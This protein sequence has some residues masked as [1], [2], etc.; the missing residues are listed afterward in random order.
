MRLFI[1]TNRDLAS[2]YNL[3]LLLP[4]ICPLFDIRVFVSDKVG[5][6]SAEAPPEA[7]Q[8]LKFFEQ[9]MPNQLLFPALE[10]QQREARGQLLTFEELSRHYNIP[11]VSWNDVRS[12][13]SLAQLREWAPDLVL[14]VRYGKIFPNRFLAIPKHGVINL[15]SGL[16][17]NYRGVLAI[18]RALSNGDTHIY[19]TLHYIDDNSIDTGRVIGYG[20][21]AVNPQ[22]SL[23]WHILHLYPACTETIVEA[24][25]QIREGRTPAALSQQQE[26]AAYYT[27]P[28]AAEIE[29]FKQKGWTWLDTAAYQDF[30]AQYL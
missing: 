13:E 27:F 2:N 26:N 25:S 1:F 12:E 17:P 7:L 9:Q 28:T 18:F 19:G 4:H 8:L 3:N 16:L 15:H 20:Q 22:Q 11:V 6:S 10:Q 30:M 23:L 24:L 21:L 14:S 5:K 29:A